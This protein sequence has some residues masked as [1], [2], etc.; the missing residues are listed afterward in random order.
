MKILLQ[1][2]SK[3]VL[4]MLS[5]TSVI[6]SVLTFRYLSH[7][8]FVFVNDVRNFSILLFYN[9]LFSFPRTSI[10]KVV[11]FPFYEYTIFYLSNFFLLVDI[12]IA[13][14]FSLL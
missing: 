7:F 4:P 13:S 10:K 2:R 3:G 8:A 11:F 14:C 12:Y 9:W 6:F 1:F 5:Y